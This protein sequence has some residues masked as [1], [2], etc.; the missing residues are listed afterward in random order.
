MA[1]EKIEAIVDGGKATAAPP[2]GPALG[3]MGVNIGQV[4]SEINKKTEAFKGMKVPVKVI[5]D[6]SSK[7]FEI[8][9]GT[10]SVSQLISKEI[11]IEKGSG[12]PN[13]NIVGNIAIE[14]AIKI[15]K[16]K[17]DAM[18]VNSLKSAVMNVVGSCNAMGIL[19]EG[20]R[21]KD[22]AKEIQAGKFDAL[23]KSEKT[24]ADPSKLKELKLQLEEIQEVYQ[25]ELAK[26]QAE[27][28]AKKAAE[29]A[30]K[31]VEGGAKPEEAEEGKEAAAAPAVKGAAAPAKAAAPVKA[32]AKGKEEK[33]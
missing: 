7:E 22:I 23:I 33:K 16:M 29:E 4:I 21:G 20:K 2:L 9:V 3:P 5:V 19:V 31:A 10:P 13:K 18:L 27:E 17:K 6:K 12:E 32:A 1:K 15:A 25:R 11:N 30:K 8:E 28:E 26:K 24:E 14:Q